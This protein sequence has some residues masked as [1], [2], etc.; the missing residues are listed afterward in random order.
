[1]AARL[2][3]WARRWVALVREGQQKYQAQA[4]KMGWARA[5]NTLKSRR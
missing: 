1:M 4:P 3:V 5:L 2:V